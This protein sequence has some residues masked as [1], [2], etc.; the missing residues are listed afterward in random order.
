MAIGACVAW[1]DA[2]CE[3]TI[4]S[5]GEDT[6]LVTRIRG[7]RRARR[8]ARVGAPDAARTANAGMAAV[9]EL[10]GRLG[11]I[12]AIDA[13]AGPI[14]QRGRGFSA[15]GLL[16]ARAAAPLAGAGV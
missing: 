11:V 13:A 7:R 9:S 10:C 8:Q 16:T 2:L 5:S 6:Y 12:G 15:G 3:V 1:D 14:K 4:I